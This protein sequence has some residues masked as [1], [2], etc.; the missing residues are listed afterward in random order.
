MLKMNLKRVFSVFISF[1]LCLNVFSA[2][3]DPEWIL[4][5][6]AFTFS[7]RG[8]GGGANEAS[9]K[10]LPTLILEQVAENLTRMPRALEQLDRIEYDLQKERT[11]LFLQLSSAVQKRDSLVLGDLSSWRLAKK[12]R[13]EEEKIAEIQKKISEN[14]KSVDAEREKRS[15]MIR[16]DTEREKSMQEGRLFSEDGT[17]DSFVRRIVENF[18]RDGGSRRQPVEKIVLYRNDSRELFS[19]SESVRLQGHESYEFSKACTEAGIRGLVTGKVTVYGAYISVS[20]TVYRYPGG[21]VIG[22]A[23]DVGSMDE[24]KS[25]ATRLSGQ[26]APKISDS[27]PVELKI[28]VSP[29]EARKNL[30]LT[31]DDVVYTDGQ[32]SIVVS[33]G[34]HFIQFASKGFDTEATSFNFS[35]NR[36]FSIE[37]EMKRKSEGEARVAIANFLEG[38]L[39]AKGE[40]RGRIDGENRFSSIKVDSRPV[41]AH[42]VSKDGFPSDF[43]IQTSLLEEDALLSLRALDFD[44]S[45]CIDRRRVSMYRAYSSL[46]ISLMPTFYV[47]GNYGNGATGFSFLSGTNEADVLSVARYVTA[48]VS[49]GCGLWFGIELVRYLVAANSTLPVEARRMDEKT[50]GK[51]EAEKPNIKKIKGLEEDDGHETN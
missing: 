29:E 17:E 18:S 4:A 12:I 32:E 51:I 41:L 21:R 2:G 49:V 37:V 11:S 19:P 44:R 9:L 14:L 33:S 28:S 40:F 1:F 50:L 46:I 10:V 27:M 3:K 35:G 31:L 8:A 24:L 20:A 45:A 23:T 15:E 25:L 16:R 36:E 34:V 22:S 7:Q 48:G 26:I 43:I 6:E 39:F 13:D 5:A 38:D 47:L 30:V 42:F